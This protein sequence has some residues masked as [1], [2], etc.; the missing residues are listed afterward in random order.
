MKNLISLLVTMGICVLVWH[1]KKQEIAEQQANYALLTSDWPM[2]VAHN[3]QSIAPIQCGQ[4]IKWY[5][6]DVDPSLDISRQQARQLIRTATEQ[7][8]ATSSSRLFEETSAQG[9]A[10]SFRPARMDQAAFKQA[11]YNGELIR[12]PHN[13]LMNPDKVFVHEKQPQ[14][15][16]TELRNQ[17]Q[18]VQ[19]RI[20][21]LTHIKDAGQAI[22]KNEFFKMQQL[23]K[24]LHAEISLLKKQ[25]SAPEAP[26][27]LPRPLSRYLHTNPRIEILAYGS[28][29]DVQ[30]SLLH[31]LG[32]ALG[33]TH[34]NQPASIMH[35]SINS[36]QRQLTAEDL[37]VA[38]QRCP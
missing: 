36:L 5:L 31:Q 37:T 13:P 17:I 25:H 20:T 34:S 15:A 16:I 26:P 24:V 6:A 29:E 33:L 21:E 3:I 27:P 7:W 32:H 19:Q 2:D 12:C 10:I 8:Q 22:D 1:L 23:H 4:P 30:V 14:Q 18:A 28:V 38:S 11:L 9:I 35:Q